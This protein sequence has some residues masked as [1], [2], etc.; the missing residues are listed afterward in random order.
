LKRR[1]RC[2]EATRG[3]QA[4]QGPQAAVE[5]R[6]LNHR[7]REA[8]NT[9]SPTNRGAASQFYFEQ[10]SLR[11]IA[12]QA[13][14]SVAAVKNRL[15][16]AR[17]RLIEILSPVYAEMVH[18]AL[19]EIRREVMVDVTI[20]DVM[21]RDEGVAFVTLL[22]GPGHRILAIQIEYQQG[23]AISHC[24]DV[25]R[26]G[27]AIS[28]H[29]QSL[30]PE[31]DFIAN[32]LEEAGVHVQEVRIE[33]LNEKILL[34]VVKMK[35]GETVHEL[36][37]RSSDVIALAARTGCPIRVSE[38][39][40]VKA[41]ENIPEEL[42]G[43]PERMFP[44]QKMLSNAELTIPHIRALENVHESLAELLAATVSRTTARRTD[45]CIAFVDTPSFGEY[46]DFLI[47]HPGCT[48]G[49]TVG[50]MK[51]KALLG[52]P[53]KVAHALLGS[54]QPEKLSTLTEDETDRLEPVVRAVLKD[55]EATWRPLVPVSIQDIELLE[56]TESAGIAALHAPVYVI[57][58]DVS[59]PGDPVP[60]TLCYPFATIFESA[61]PPLMRSRFLPK[62]R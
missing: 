11:E 29:E 48:Y 52:L 40:L 21:Q 58:F 13:G 26:G 28:T 49:F 61:L 6:E 25:P 57:G 18:G 44:G 34:G 24:L 38:E 16:R 36:E 33:T 42:W 10:L 7:V 14:V 2:T 30:P 20:A 5:K 55:L 37:A 59:L 62:G 15:Y 45:G 51:G 43:H 12:S 56:D 19:D 35:S 1:A 50:G 47:E 17:K 53:G 3:P 31:G 54:A 46:V 22:D 4:I 39:V 23:L 41:G 9:L 27:D 8:V 32:L 60:I